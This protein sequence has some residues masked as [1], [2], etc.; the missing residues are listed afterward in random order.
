M[1]PRTTISRRYRAQQRASRPM[2]PATLRARPEGRR[3]GFGE[4]SARERTVRLAVRRC[5]EGA[6]RSCCH[7]RGAVSDLAA[8]H[9]LCVEREAL[10]VGIR[11]H[12]YLDHAPW[13]PL[14]RTTIIFD[15]AQAQQRAAD[16]GNIVGC[17]G[18]H[19]RTRVQ[20]LAHVTD[21]GTEIRATQRGSKHLPAPTHSTARAS[22]RGGEGC[23]DVGEG[24]A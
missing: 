12:L 22:L 10:L 13:T 19:A 14:T 18:E 15:D 3:C 20:H 6:G 11:A 17:G 7:L 23:L 2:T 4:S 21:S 1:R 9:T 16:T 8:G 5:N 24:A